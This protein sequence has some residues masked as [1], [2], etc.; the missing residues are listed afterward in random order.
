ML[1]AIGSSLLLVSSALAQVNFPP[2]VAPANN[3]TTTE[4]ALLGM[5]LFFEEQLSTNNK[6]ACATCHN[7]T[8][9]GIDLRTA[10]SVNPGMDGTYGTSD[11]QRGS[12]GT[13]L[14][15]ANGQLIAQPNLGLGD[16][17]T[18]R[19]TPTVINSGYHTHLGYEG[20][21]ASLEDLVALPPINPREMGHHGRTW[22]DVINKL[23]SA[24]PLTLASNLPTRLQ[25]FL[26]GHSYPDLFQIAYG[27]S[28]LTQSLVTSALS[29]YLRTLNSDQSKWDLH[30]HQQAT[31]TAEEQLGLT[32]FT[33]TANGA[34]A[35]STCHGDF[36]TNGPQTGPI[37]GQMTQVTVGYYGSSVPTRLV[38]H[39]VGL[40]PPVED[41]GRANV[42]G[43]PTDSGLFRIASLRNVELAAPYFH[44][45]SAATLAD[46][47]DFYDRGGDVHINQAPSLTPRSYT[48]AEKDAL[49]AI[50]KTL[51]DPRIA[52]G[53]E[54]FDQPTLGS[55]NGNLVTAVG[56]STTTAS[57]AMKAT[58]PF[59]AML[60]ESRFQ[61]TLTGVT[62]GTP[63]FLMWDRALRTVSLPFN[64]ELALSGDFQM[65]SMGPAGGQ[66]TMPGSGLQI[67]NIAIPSNAALSGQTLFAQWLVLEPSNQG[68]VATSNALRVPL[69]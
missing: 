30:L 8:Q 34:T 66:W 32:L 58:A 60:G 51:T 48:Q 46:A 7:L 25:N 16:Q 47:I 59:A 22:A 54:P 38:F 1:R 63:T 40:R 33:S 36:N 26:A 56:N 19:R 37:A 17:I 43:L 23:T 50:L 42:T 6:V 55:Q 4:R 29:A 64:L 10:A 15:L 27:S 18:F 44:N 13:P 5:A 62:V 35:C 28:V 20:R 53:V 65:F 57:G 14:M 12:P 41:P 52:A 2:P 39:N 9:A 68:F 11:D 24:T 61:I 69:H 3:Q 45:G 31:L 49:V 67:A 21:Q